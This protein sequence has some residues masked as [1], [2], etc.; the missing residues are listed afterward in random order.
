[1]AEGQTLAT[2]IIEFV[3]EDSQYQSMK[4][5]I[6]SDAAELADIFKPTAGGAKTAADAIKGI[7][8]AAD[9][10]TPKVRATG[11]GVEDLSARIAALR[12]RADAVGAALGRIQEGAGAAAGGAARAGASVAGLSLAFTGAAAAAIVAAAAIGQYLAYV[13]QVMAAQVEI[14]AAVARFDTSALQRGADQAAAS[15]RAYQDALERLRLESIAAQTGGETIVAAIRAVKGAID[16]TIATFVQ[17]QQG[18]IKTYNEFGRMNEA[19]QAGKA[20]A[21]AA[22]AAFGLIAQQAPNLDQ[23]RAALEQQNE[24]LSEAAELTVRLAEQE[25]KRVKAAMEGE[26]KLLQFLGKTQE[27]I[28]KTEQMENTMAE[29]ANQRASQREQNAAQAAEREVQARMKVADAAGKQIQAEEAVTQAVLQ[30]AQRRIQAASQEGTARLAAAQQQ[31]QFYDK[32]VE[33]LDE[34]YARQRELIQAGDQLEIQSAQSRLDAMVR[35]EN[36]KIQAMEQGS[37]AQTTAITNLLAKETDARSKIDGMARDNATKMIQYDTQVAQAK[38]Q[39]VEQQVQAEARYQ[40]FLVSTG[41]ATAEA[42]IRAQ[43]QI[44]DAEGAGIN[45]RMAAAQRAL[46][47]AKQLEQERFT[48]AQQMGQVTMQ[49]QIAFYQRI[50]DRASSTE[51]EKQAAALKADAAIR[52]SLTLRFK[53]EEAMGQAN[54]EDQ[55]EFAE[56]IAKSYRQGSEQATE[57]WVQAAAKRR[58]AD[59]AQARAAA[60]LMQQYVQELTAAGQKVI[61]LADM[62]RRAGQ[63]R[64]NVLKTIDT[65]LRGGSVSAEAFSRALTMGPKFAEMAQAGNDASGSIRKNFQMMGDQIRG[66][67][68]NMAPVTSGFFTLGEKAEQSGSQVDQAFEDMNRNIQNVATTTVALATYWRNLPAIAAPAFQGLNQLA[69]QSAGG[70][71]SAFTQAAL[72]IP[73]A[74]QTAFAQVGPMFDNMISQLQNKV[75]AGTS[76]LA[77]SIIQSFTSQLMRMLDDFRARS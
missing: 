67:G 30:G 65:L 44:A 54:A 55:A 69:I 17:F 23:M 33:G 40:S 46:Q 8:D 20:E 22:A 52:Q 64:A 73:G 38:Q 34:F 49:Q 56:A 28:Q 50:A 37:Q 74:F 21:Q 71:V 36:L 29:R 62:E 58:Q 45:A 39:N 24:A 13:E 41:Q 77:N 47:M 14:N 66:V 57:A 61:S 7:G 59:E 4:Q 76:S 35:T 5:K 53:L 32:A 9:K 25:D 18:L 12:E 75:I 63:D 60:G 70:I 3:G 43:Q 19:M 10:T 27:V 1:M 51:Q 16:P 15:V 2:A 68:A 6:L 11:S 42:A 72:G 48:F 31:A 26:I